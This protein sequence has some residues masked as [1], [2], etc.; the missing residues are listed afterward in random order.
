MREGN[1]RCSVVARGGLTIF[2]DIAELGA[3][4][5]RFQT[6]DGRAHA[7]P[8]FLDGARIR[9]ALAGRPRQRRCERMAARQRQPRRAFEHIGVDGDGLIHARIRQRQCAGFVEHDRVGFGEPFDCVTAVEND[10]AAKQR[11]CGDHL[12]GRDGKRNRARTGND[13]HG[14]GDD[15][16]IVQRGSRNEP[17]DRCQRRRRMHDRRVKPRRA[18]GEPHGPRLCFDSLVEE[19]LDFIDQRAGSGGSDAYGQS[20]G[21]IDAAGVDRHAAAYGAM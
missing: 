8:G 21:Y 16:R 2:D 19:P 7:L 18:I 3:A 11:A 20:A 13:E 4:K 15:N 6:V 12:H 5:A 9:T 10:A 17:A 1:E 14:D